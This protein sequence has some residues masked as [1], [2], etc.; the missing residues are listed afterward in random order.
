MVR[1]S[2]RAVLKP[3]ARGKGFVVTFPDL[4]EALTGGRNLT[5]SLSEAADCLGEALAFRMVE[6]KDIPR[7]S[8]PRK[9]QL[10]IDIPLYLAPKVG[11]YTAMR[12]IRMTNSELARR[13]GYTETVVRRM[14]NPRHHSRPESMQAALA[15][16]GQRILVLVDDAA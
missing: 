4:P 3:E 13:L 12:R 9:G 16:V 7:P 14:L 11:L 1:L 10:L 15:A 5:E 2:Y 8:A 6:K